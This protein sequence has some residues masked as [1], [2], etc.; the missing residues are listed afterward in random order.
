[1]DQ[2]SLFIHNAFDPISTT[3]ELCLIHSRENIT[4][5]YQ[6]GPFLSMILELGCS[7]VPNVH[8]SSRDYLSGCHVQ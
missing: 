2:K 6:K 4:E 8:E 5:L 7:R 1:M 3:I